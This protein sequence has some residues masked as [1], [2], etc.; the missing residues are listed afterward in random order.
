MIIWLGGKLV[1]FG[2]CKF[3]WLETGEASNC[4][5][6]GFADEGRTLGYLG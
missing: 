6:S 3:T 4:N 5:P 2:I 1:L